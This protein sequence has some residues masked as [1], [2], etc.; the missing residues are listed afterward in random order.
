MAVGRCEY[1]IAKG[2]SVRARAILSA[3]ESVVPGLRTNRY[4]GKVHWLMGWGSGYPIHAEAMEKHTASG[5]PA[6]FWD[7]GYSADHF[8]VSL[9]WHHPR[10]E[11]LDRTPTDGRRFHME[12]RSDYDPEGPILVIGMGRKSKQLLNRHDW[13][14]KAVARLREQR[15]GRTII[16]RPKPGNSTTV[17]GVQIDRSETIEQALRGKS[18]VVCRHSNVGIDATIAG[19]PIQTED[20][21]AKW[22]EGKPFDVETRL[23]FLARVAWWQWRPDEA[24]QA[25]EFLRRMARAS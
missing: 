19:V 5:R 21:A 14:L 9:G 23:E 4:S 17:M 24:E 6:A 22:L 25:W 8:R 20:G 16:V 15:P 13:E 10:P 1:L 3:M 2:P 7:L 18:L 12:L 11:Q